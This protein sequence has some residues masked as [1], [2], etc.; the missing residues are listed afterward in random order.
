MHRIT[1]T[2][3][4]T[5]PTYPHSR[6]AYAKLAILRMRRWWKLVRMRAPK[7]IVDKDRELV[8]YAVRATLV[9]GVENDRRCAED[10]KFFDTWV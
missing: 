6:F 2:A 4:P 3:G 10:Q 1:I 8:W 9:P 5:G 7:I